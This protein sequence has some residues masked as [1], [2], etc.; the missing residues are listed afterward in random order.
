MMAAIARSDSDPHHEQEPEF[1]I[2]A[3]DDLTPTVI[4]NLQPLRDARCHGRPRSRLS[5]FTPAAM[6][7]LYEMIAGKSSR[8]SSSPRYLT[9]FEII[10]CIS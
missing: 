3:M 10:L 2:H 7:C 4:V 5:S 1:V 6:L 8:V 9:S